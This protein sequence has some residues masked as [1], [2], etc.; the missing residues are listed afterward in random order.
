M[1]EPVTEPVVVKKKDKKIVEN[2]HRTEGQVRE[3][4]HVLPPLGFDADFHALHNAYKSLKPDEFEQFIVFF[5]E[6]GRNMTAQSP[7]GETIAELIK[8]HRHG[9]EYLAVL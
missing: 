1:T 8:Q 5:K 9:D 4:L 7:Y 6:A 2:E 3:F